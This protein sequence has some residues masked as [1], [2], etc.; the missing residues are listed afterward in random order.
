MYTHK[1]INIVYIYIIHIL[2]IHS[3]YTTTFIKTF[4]T[5]IQQ[6]FR[7]IFYSFIRLT[8]NF[9]MYNYMKL[10]SIA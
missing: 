7:I 4:I 2:Y 8:E 3:I 1:Y 10:K 9:K 5:C 6:Y